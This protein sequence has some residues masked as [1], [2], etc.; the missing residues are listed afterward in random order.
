[1]A[2]ERK[3]PKQISHTPPVGLPTITVGMELAQEEPFLG[4]VLLD[5]HEEFD[6]GWRVHIGVRPVD[7][8]VGKGTAEKAGTG[9][10][11]SQY[12]IS[13][14]AKSKMGMFVAAMKGVFPDGTPLG[15]G[16]LV[17]QVAIFVR[18]DIQFGKDKETGQPIT[19]SGTLIP[20]RAATDEERERAL[21][22]S[23]ARGIEMPVNGAQEL[24]WNPEEITLLVS[25]LAGKTES[26]AQL[27]AAKS[28]LAP[29]LKQALMKGTAAQQLIAHEYIEM[30]DDRY[31]SLDAQLEE[32]VS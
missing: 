29:E 19:A 16:Q 14:S 26:E 4:V 9:M 3:G 30:V 8:E 17:G 2:E 15:Q 1:M 28:R 32:A 31:V 21:G 11:H 7:F 24:P 10:F 23:A 5:Q 22:S 13:A 12:P 20:L 18:R 27:A 6:F 25:H